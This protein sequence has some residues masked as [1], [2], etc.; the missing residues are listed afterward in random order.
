MKGSEEKEPKARNLFD[1]FLSLSKSKRLEEGDVDRYEPYMT[2]KIFSHTADTLFHANLMNQYYDLPKEA[3][4]DFYLYGTPGKGRYSEWYKV[5]TPPEE[6]AHIRL[7]T[8]CS[9]KESFIYFDLLESL[10]KKSLAK[11][12]KGGTT[13]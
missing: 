2:N 6:L 12:R 10:Q 8:G 7:Q 5:P 4:M 3:Q 9:N 11:V 1:I 13:K